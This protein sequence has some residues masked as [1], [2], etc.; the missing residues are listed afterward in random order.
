M[1]EKGLETGYFAKVDSYGFHDWK[2]CVSRKF[3]WF[4][5]RWKLFHYPDL[6]PSEELLKDWKE[7][8]ITWEEY[9]TRYRNEITSNENSMEQLHYLIY[10][11]QYTVVRLMC[12]EKEAPC[13]RF[14]LEDMMREYFDYEK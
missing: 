2:A 3:P 12:W 13:H 6:A 8:K 9:E 5:K 4:V 1:I 11:S 10:I 7:E 14:I